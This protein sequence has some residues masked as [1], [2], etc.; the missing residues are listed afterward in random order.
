LALARRRKHAGG[1]GRPPG[2]DFTLHVRRLCDDIVRSL[3]ELSHVDMNRVAV[4]FSQTRKSSNYGMYAALTPMRFADGQIHSVR[5]GRKWGVQQ[6]HDSGGQQMLYILTFYLP[7]FL[8]LPF[9]DKLS[10]VFH[11][12]WHIDPKFNGDSRRFPGRCHAHGS[13]QAKYDARVSMLME[14]W[15]SLDPP[16]PVY[17]FLRQDFAGLVAQHGRVFGQRIATP[18][19]IA[20]G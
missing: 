19:L 5:R 14:R 12:L 1:N 11:E 13:S 6:L 20:V 9:R 15:L 18:K 2:F 10:T 17:D 4:G 16:L 7:R 3:P 8:D